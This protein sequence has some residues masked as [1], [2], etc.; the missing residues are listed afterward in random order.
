MKRGE[1][2]SVEFDPAVGSE[3]RKKRP[4]LIVSNDA[5]NRNLAR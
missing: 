2:W 1:V 4:A 5:A 3:I